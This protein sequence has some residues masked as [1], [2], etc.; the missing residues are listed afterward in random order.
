MDPGATCSDLFG[1]LNLALARSEGRVRAVDPDA[2]EQGRGVGRKHRSTTVG[3]LLVHVADHTQRHVGQA[4][5]T[6]KI[7]STLGR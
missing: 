3:G 1:E 2:L 6:A 5:T 7:V 4:I